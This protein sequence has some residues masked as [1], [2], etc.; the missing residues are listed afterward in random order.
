MY[1]ALIRSTL[2]YGVVWDPYKQQAIQS[3]EKKNQRQR[4][5]FNKND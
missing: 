3:L 1:T 4:T 2:E 5:R